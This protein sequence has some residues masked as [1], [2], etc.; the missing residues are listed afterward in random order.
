[1]GKGTAMR[2]ILWGLAGLVGAAVIG[3]GGFVGWVWFA[4]EAHLTSFPEPSAFAAP[5][6]TD[7]ASLERG[8]HLA[9][10][11]GCA[12]CHGKQ[13]QGDTAG[14]GELMGQNVAPNLARLA[15]EESPVLFERALRHGIGR[16]GRALYSM[17]SF[18]FARMTDADVAALYAYLRSVPVVEA[19]L[20]KPFL[21]WK[22]RYAL[23]TGADGAIPVFIK[24]TPALSFQADPDPAVRRGEY[25]AMT[26]CNEC[27][28]FGLR[29]DNPFDPPG[30]A[31]P[32]LAMVG[33]WQKADFV[34][35]MRTGKGA[36]GREL[37]LMSGVARGRF[38]HFTDQE[39]DDL[40]VFFGA[41]NEQAN[42]A[43]RQ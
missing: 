38:A 36:G 24:Q 31:P 41:L 3:F 7:A 1:M 6:P 30:K 15:R 20:P 14:K 8:R 25:L 35:L 5:I 40:Y 39:V 11:R 19:N 34:T 18:N 26:S 27:H 37:R 13:F 23:A 32:D 2:T 10:T 22:V 29:G 16:D 12:G 33:V 28:G 43:P 42:G 21:D 17:P 4:S 9:I